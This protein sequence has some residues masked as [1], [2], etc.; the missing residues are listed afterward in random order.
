MIHRTGSL[1]DFY[2]RVT[3][4]IRVVLY[5]Q[6]L[7]VIIAEQPIGND[8]LACS[9]Y[10]RLSSDE[11]LISF[12]PIVKKERKDEKQIVTLLIDSNWLGF[13]INTIGYIG[14]VLSCEFS[15][16]SSTTWTI[17]IWRIMYTEEM[18]REREKKQENAKSRVT[19]QN[20]GGFPMLSTNQWR[21]K[22][23]Y[24]LSIPDFL[25]TFTM[26]FSHDKE[27]KRKK[28]SRMCGKKKKK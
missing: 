13:Q 27:K 28:T 19:K 4:K 14:Q 18:K 9:T 20:R 25:R 1:L 7:N 5:S 21:F 2:I 24:K 10:E 8:S 12:Y 17:N 3:C 26:D 16:R 23:Y 15:K 22:S 6:I 11:I